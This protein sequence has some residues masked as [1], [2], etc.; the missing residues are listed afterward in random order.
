MRQLVKHLNPLRLG[1]G[2]G[3]LLALF[4][5][6]PEQSCGAAGSTAANNGITPPGKRLQIGQAS[7]MADEIHGRMT[8]NGELYDM[9]QLSAAHRTLPFHTLVEVRNL[10]N[11]KIVRVRINDRGPYA[12]GRI[13]DLSF[14]AAQVIGLVESG[15]GLVELRILSEK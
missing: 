8:A 15:S 14:A 3:L 10:L 11:N 12:K 5:S 2:L 6:R 7:F 1:L 13:I 4:V 9:R